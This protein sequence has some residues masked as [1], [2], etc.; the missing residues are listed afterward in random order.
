MET[1]TSKANHFTFKPAAQSQKG[2]IH[3]WLKQEHIQKWMHGEGLNNTLSGLTAF[4]DYYEKG[5][6]IDKDLDLT[7]HWI[8]YEGD[9][10][11]VYLLTSNVFENE[12][13]I[14]AKHKQLGAHAI[15]LDIFIGNTLYLGKGLAVKIITE[16]LSSHFPGIDEV[17]IDPEQTNERAIHVY[18]KAGFKQIDTF[19]ASWHPVAHT[20]MK[21][22][23]KSFLKNK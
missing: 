23:M 7:Q 1:K 22:D 18:Q 9:T 8:G 2:L 16:F 21:C 5:G 14:Y 3:G 10:P 12:G 15:T 17:F 20:L 11:F 13:S 19:I 6:R 4:I